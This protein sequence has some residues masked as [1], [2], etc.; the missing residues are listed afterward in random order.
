MPAENEAGLAAQVYEAGM[1]AETDEDPRRHHA[2]RYHADRK[3]L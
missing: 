3:T 2:R 1:V